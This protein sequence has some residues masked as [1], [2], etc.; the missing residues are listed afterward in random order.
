MPRSA[1]HG[2]YRRATVG[3]GLAAYSQSNLLTFIHTSDQTM[4]RWEQPSGNSDGISYCLIG[5]EFTARGV[6]SSLLL[7]SLGSGRAAD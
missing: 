3:S 4:C 2:A 1:V 7:V 6:S 5:S